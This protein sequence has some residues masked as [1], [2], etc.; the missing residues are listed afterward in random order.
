MFQYLDIDDGKHKN[1][2]K[3]TEIEVIMESIM[4]TIQLQH[5]NLSRL[6]DA[7]YWCGYDRQPV[8]IH[9]A[10]DPGIGKTYASKSLDRE[11]GVTYFSASYSPNEYRGFNLFQR[12]VQS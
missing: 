10:G 6:I 2:V 9:I 3:K 11:P 8:F 4:A 7:A 1:R 12:I 5:L